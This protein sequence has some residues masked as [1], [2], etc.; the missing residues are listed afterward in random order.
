MGS[1]PACVGESTGVADGEEDKDEKILA[2]HTC[3][4]GVYTAGPPRCLTSLGVPRSAL[5]LCGLVGAEL[6]RHYRGA[7]S[8]MDIPRS[9]LAQQ[10][11]ANDDWRSRAR[12]AVLRGEAFFEEAGLVWLSPSTDDGVDLSCF[13]SLAECGHTACA[14]TRSLFPAV[15]KSFQGEVARRALAAHKRMDIPNSI[16]YVSIGSGL[17][18]GDLCVL[19]QLQHIGFEIAAA[20]FVDLDYG[21]SDACHG[22]L[23]AMAEYL[24]PSTHVIAFAST[25]E[26]ALARLRGTQPAAHIFAQIDVAE[27]SFDEAAALSAIALDDR[28]GGLG[29]RLVNQDGACATMDAWRR[30]P[31]PAPSQ[32]VLDQLRHDAVQLLLQRERE[33]HGSSDGK[34]TPKAVLERLDPRPLLLIELDDAVLGTSAGS[35]AAA[36]S[37]GNRPQVGV[38]QDEGG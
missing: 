34:R 14:C 19:M 16:H 36:A 23:A 3:L 17:L 32:A 8:I 11:L 6:Y 37:A 2:F 22:A 38:G 21:T 1:G 25:E 20:T 12:R 4:F 10:P 28:G 5:G 31:T 24:S 26:Y 18:L 29:F 27:V 33:A 13:A 7:E 30:R 9:S 35:G 15:R